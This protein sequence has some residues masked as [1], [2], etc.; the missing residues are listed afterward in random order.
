M[1]GETVNTV[2]TALTVSAGLALGVERILEF[3]KQRLNAGNNEVSPAERNE[4]IE[5]AKQT[6]EE[7]EKKLNNSAPVNALEIGVNTEPAVAVMP[8]AVDSEPA[9]KYDPPKIEIVKMQA[10]SPVATAKVLFL[11]LGG[12]GLGIIMAWMFDIQLI[13]LMAGANELVIPGFLWIKP[14]DII[15]TGLVIGGG[16]Q[17]IHVMITF[18]TERKVVIGAATEQTGSEKENEKFKDMARAISSGNLVDEKKEESP[19]AWKNI[20]YTG[21]VKPETMDDKHLRPGNPNLIVYHHT[22]MSSNSSFQSVVDEFLIN[23]KWLTGYHC[24]IMPD[25]AIQ[26][27][28]RWDRRGNHT[29]GLNE[30]SLGISFHGNFHTKAGDKFSNADGRFGNQHPTDA[31]Y[32]AGARVVALW[33]CLY[34]DIDRD[35]NKSILPHNEAIKNHTVCPGSNF[36]HKLFRKLIQQYYEAWAASAVAQENIEKFRDKTQTKYIYV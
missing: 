29:R 34:S 24:V 17:P 15:F 14:L 8:V 25:G 4:I 16:S 32:H 3:L 20:P 13:S 36:D 22:A 31:Q 9:E 28:C 27:F 33:A 7:A 35:F 5:R 11:Q 19:F 26:P 12:A 21:G 23:K 2:I 10:D 18:L 6:V 1:A 30:R